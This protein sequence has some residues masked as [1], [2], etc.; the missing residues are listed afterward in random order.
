LTII[1]FAE[2]I[3]FTTYK[4]GHISKTLTTHDY[5]RRSQGSA[6]ALQG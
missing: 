3:E 6:I 2:S 1:L 5:K 4:G